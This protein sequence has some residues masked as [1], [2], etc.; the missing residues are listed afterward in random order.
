MSEN[1][2]RFSLSPLLAAGKKPPYFGG[3]YMMMKKK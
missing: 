2:N 1:F 3:I